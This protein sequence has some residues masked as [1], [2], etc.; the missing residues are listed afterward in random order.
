MKTTLTA[1]VLAGIISAQA[2]LAEVPDLGGREVVVARARIP[3]ARR[4]IAQVLR[5]GRP[6][7]GRKDHTGECNLGHA[8]SLRFATVRRCAGC[9]QYRIGR[10]EPAG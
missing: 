2:V 5:G 3:P 6:G 9:A 4:T 7:A 1:V 10:A 8:R